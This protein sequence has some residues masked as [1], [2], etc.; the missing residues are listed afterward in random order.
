MNK[1]KNDYKN[2]FEGAD[3][4]YTWGIGTQDVYT[5]YSGKKV[6]PNAEV[7]YNMNTHTKEVVNPMISSGSSTV[8]KI[9]QNLVK[10]KKKYLKLL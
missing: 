4:I 10:Y 5:Q 3:D 9:N 6:N 2:Y 7:V 1:R 8:I